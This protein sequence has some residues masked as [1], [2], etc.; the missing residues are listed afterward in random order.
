MKNYFYQLKMESEQV[1]QVFVDL[2]VLKEMD[3]VLLTGDE[4]NFNEWCLSQKLQYAGCK[5]TNS[6][7][8]EDV[9]HQM[10]LILKTQ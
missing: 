9:K 7:T 1:F 2:E 10:I 6:D 8:I 4:N 5:F 3:R